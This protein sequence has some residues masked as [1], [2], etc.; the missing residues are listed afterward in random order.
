[1]LKFTDE[2]VEELYKPVIRKF[3]R[4]RVNVNGIDE[5]WAAELIDLQAFSKDNNGIKYLLT[6]IDIF[7]KFVWIVPLKRKTGPEVAN[8]FL[9]ILKE[10]RSSK[11]WVD[12]G[13]EFYNKD[14][15]KLVELYTTENEEKSCVIETFNRTIKKEMF[16]YF[17]AN[18]TSKFVNVLDLLVDQYN[19]TIRSSIKIT[20]KEGSRKENENKVW[21]NLYPECGGKTLAP[22]CSIGD[23]VRITKKKKTF[24]KGYTQRQTEAVFK[25]SIIQLTIP[26]TY[27]ITD[28]YGEEIQGSFDEQQLQKTKQDIF[29][30]EKIIKQ[31]GNKSLVKQL[32][33]ND[34]FNSWVYNEDINKLQ[35]QSS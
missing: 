19:N 8:V 1:M 5:I 12:K 20:P 24:D 30:I 29:R 18:Y 6:V 3:Q 14:V 26:V 10:R 33:Y 27:K 23:H 21:R 13:R 22:K 16:K 25:I 15:Q 4:R 34:S 32:G 31:Q 2:L 17:S 11:M 28:Y 9:R 35:S 7:S